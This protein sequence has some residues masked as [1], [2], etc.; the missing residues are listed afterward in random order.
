MNE[1]HNGLLKLLKQKH[2][3][4]TALAESCGVTF[5]AVNRWVS[6]VRKP[7]IENLPKIAETLNCSYE[8]IVTAI[9]SEKTYEEEVVMVVN[10]YVEM[11]KCGVTQ[12]MLADTLNISKRSVSSKM[13]GDKEFT[14]SEMY[15]IRDTYFADKTIDE[16]FAC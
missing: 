5:Q 2:I 15:K 8:D 16:L 9:L 4:Q 3:S 6:G 13:R 1:H 10:L 12:T 14:A 7:S 11:K